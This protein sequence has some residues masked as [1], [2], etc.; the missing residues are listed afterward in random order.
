M[1]DLNLRAVSLIASLS[2]NDLCVEEVVKQDGMTCLLSSLEAHADCDDLVEQ[3]I[4]ALGTLATKSKAAQETLIEKNGIQYIVKAMMDH[5]D[6]DD[7]ATAAVAAL[8]RMTADDEVSAKI[9]EVGMHEI[10]TAIEVKQNNAEIGMLTELYVLVG[11][12]AFERRDLSGIVQCGGVAKVIN[13]ICAFPDNRELVRRGVQTLDNIAMGSAEHT[14][15][16]DQE[17]GKDCIEIV[18]ETYENDEEILQSCRSALL[19]MSALQTGSA[20]QWK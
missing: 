3:G 19:S 7:I 16:V 13:G 20:A 6:N 9:G 4:T 15:I 5:L 10:L 18:Q 8:T 1:L 14:Q 11:H 12:L 17:G 2:Y